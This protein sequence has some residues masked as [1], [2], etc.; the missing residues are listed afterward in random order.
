MRAL[1]IIVG[2]VMG[3]MMTIQPS[4]SSLSS[5]P[6]RSSPDLGEDEEL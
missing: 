1:R 4:G 2:E 6:D 5:R 3:G